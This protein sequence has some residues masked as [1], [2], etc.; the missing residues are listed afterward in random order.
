MSNNFKEMLS[1]LFETIA[2]NCSIGLQRIQR[3]TALE[4]SKEQSDV[5]TY[6]KNK[7]T[8]EK[9]N[10]LRDVLHDK[11]ELTDEDYDMLVIGSAITL[12]QLNNQKGQL[13]MVINNIEKQIIPA[14][15]EVVKAEN[16][17]QKFEEVFTKMLDKK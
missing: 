3:I 17:Q 9:F 10:H 12:Q 15:C 5:E 7:Q 8:L 1:E 13:E 2:N 16:R 6:K 4:E 14:L 11:A